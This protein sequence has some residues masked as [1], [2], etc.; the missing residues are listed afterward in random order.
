MKLKEYIDHFKK[1]GTELDIRC[2]S[3]IHFVEPSTCWRF[4]HPADP[5]EFFCAL[6]EDKTNTSGPD[7][8]E[9]ESGKSSKGHRMKKYKLYVDVKLCQSEL[10]QVIVTTDIEAPFYEELLDIVKGTSDKGKVVDIKTEK[11]YDDIEAISIEEP[12]DPHYHGYQE[13]KDDH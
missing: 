8:N 7:D 9:C 6:W 1:S 11:I 3:C 10:R 5:N 4:R 2:R 13:I 12:E